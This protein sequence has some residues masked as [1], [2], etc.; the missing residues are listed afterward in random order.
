[1]AVKLTKKQAHKYLDSME[2]KQYDHDGWYGFQ[3]VDSVNDF[4]YKL[5]GTSL[6][7]ASAKDLP[8]VND[9]KGFAKVYENTKSFKAQKGDIVV[10]GPKY[11]SGHGHTEI[12]INGNYDG[13]YMKFQSLGQNWLS[14]GWTEGPA[15]GGT[16]WEKNTKNVHAYDFPMWFIR[17][18]YKTAVNKVTDKVKETTKKVVKKATPK[19]A[20]KKKNIVL[21]SGHGGSDPGAVGN[22]TTE[23]DFIRKNITPNVAKLLKA[24]G[25]KVTIYGTKQNL[26]ADT[27]Y[28]NQRGNYKDY[29]MY[30]IKNKLGKDAVIV[31]FHL[32]AASPSASGGHVIIS[33]SFKADA[34]D[35]AL[36]KALRNSVGT[37]RGID[38]RNNL[39]NANVSAQLNM[40]YRLVELGFITSK[41]DMDYIKKNLSSFNK[42]IAEAIGGGVI[43]DSTS[44][45]KPVADKKPTPAPKPANTGAYKTNKYGTI[46]KAEKG[47]F[48]NGS[49]P[50]INR[51]N[52]PF[53]NQPVGYSFQPNGYTDY[54]YVL[55][56][57]GHVWI[58]YTWQ[59]KTYYLPIRTWNGVHPAKSGYSVSKAWGT[60]K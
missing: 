50:I 5:T 27:N 34:V 20:V 36:D 2:G 57:D 49:Q 32:D 59:G 19:K 1:M 31:E 28:G 45:S 18:T 11:G 51:L 16:G 42:G 39:L 9:F 33:S 14:G 3:C 7:G 24:Q 46:Y 48:T 60:F 25:H 15:K 38:P 29:G 53:L 58:E 56:Q 30:W 40:N 6:K 10:F 4:Y 52:G 35:K 13:N 43:A 37:I 8:F 21:V 23:R 22:G 26:F 41:K 55:W 47:R 54:Q 12:V 17:P 44:T